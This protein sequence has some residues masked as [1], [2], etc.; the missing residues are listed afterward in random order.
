MRE[1][2]FVLPRSASIEIHSTPKTQL[3]QET[4]LGPLNDGPSK[5]SLVRIAPHIQLN[6]SDGTRSSLEI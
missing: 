1:S 6:L 4:N 2:N 3:I 5:P